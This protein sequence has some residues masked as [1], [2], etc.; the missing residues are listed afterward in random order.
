MRE[1]YVIVDSIRLDFAYADSVYAAG[2]AGYITDNIIS[3]C[4]TRVGLQ[5]NNTNVSIYSFLGDSNKIIEKISNCYAAVI[6][7]SG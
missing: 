1:N 5:S 2:F 6:F 7:V 4:F 3:D